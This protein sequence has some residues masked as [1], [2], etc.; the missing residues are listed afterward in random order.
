MISKKHPNNSQT[1]FN[2]KLPENDLPKT[3]KTKQNILKH[4]LM[5]TKLYSH[6]TDVYSCVLMCEHAGSMC[7]VCVCVCCACVCVCVC[8]CVS[9]CTD[10]WARKI[11]VHCVGM[12]GRGG[13]HFKKTARGSYW[14]FLIFHATQHNICVMWIRKLPAA[15]P[16]GAFS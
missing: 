1:T 10:A 9:M 4:L 7:I 2:K 5:C 16:D 3:F 15:R 8:V 14:C 11:Y 13:R 12:R 6:V